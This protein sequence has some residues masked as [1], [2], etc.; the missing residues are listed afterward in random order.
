MTRK[1][2]F[3]NWLWVIVIITIFGIL[4]W[5]TRLIKNNWSFARGYEQEWIAGSLLGGYG[6]S[7]DPVTAWLGPY[8]DGTTYTPTAWAEPLNT[9]FIATVM[10]VFGEYGRLILALFNVVWL[11][12]SGIL[13]FL[14]VGNILDHKVGLYTTILFLSCMP[15]G[16]ILFYILEMPPL[17]DFYI[18]F[19]P[20]F[21]SDA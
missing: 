21:C 20:I 19:Q 8:G 14:L 15:R 12:L 3:S 16:W 4:I 6:Y 7:F 10:K 17:L 2:H 5:Q 9:L 13:I 18:V 1:L 11:G